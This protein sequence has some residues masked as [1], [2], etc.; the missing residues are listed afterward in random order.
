MS[1]PTHITYARYFQDQLGLQVVPL[2]GPVFG[3][4][5]G[6]CRCRD[7]ATCENA[8][9]HP[10]AKYRDKPS[11]LPSNIDNYAVVLGQYIVVDVDDRGVLDRLSEVMGFTLPDTW[12]I[13]T[14]HG[15]HMWYK[16]TEPC[17]TR[18]GRYEKVDLKSNNTYVVGP[19]STSVSGVVYEPINNL[20][21]ADAPQQLVEACGRPSSISSVKITREIPEVTSVF[22]MPTI[23]RYCEEMRTTNT[24]NN[25]LH[26]TVCTLLR[27]GWAGKD[28]IVMLAEAAAQAGLQAEEIQRT[29]DSAWRAVMAE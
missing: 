17:A 13:N 15:C 27:S 22:A 9:K 8:G 5:G 29:I 10:R 12:T 14:A 4:A 3:P 6:M 21:I 18:L 11:R 26:R 2:F 25:T 20:P 28:S 1:E 16:H 23:D 24:R 7:G 19:G